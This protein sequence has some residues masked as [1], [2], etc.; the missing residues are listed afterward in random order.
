MF[1]LVYISFLK[2][3]YVLEWFYGKFIFFKGYLDYYIGFF[4][5]I[6]FLIGFN[7]KKNLF[8]KLEFLNLDEKLN[9]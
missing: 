2:I 3:K 7:K 5:E 8:K 4:M 1:C 9:F 6:K